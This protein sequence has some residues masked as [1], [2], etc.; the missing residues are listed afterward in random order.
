LISEWLHKNTEAGA[1]EKAP[2]FSIYV[3]FTMQ[4][5]GYF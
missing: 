1:G 4:K 2:A 3:Y 5:G